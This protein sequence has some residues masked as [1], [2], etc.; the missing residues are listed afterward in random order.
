MVTISTLGY[1][2]LHP[3]NTKEKIYLIF[4][5]LVN[6]ALTSYLIGNMTNLVVHFTSRTSKYVST[7]IFNSS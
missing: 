3:V 7:I 1:G 6:V 4:Y 2:D 5:V